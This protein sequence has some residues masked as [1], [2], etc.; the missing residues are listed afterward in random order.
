M[1]IRNNALFGMVALISFHGSAWGA[2]TGSI[3]G[4]LK[5]PDGLVIAGAMVT[6]TNEAQGVKTKTVTGSN[7]SIL[8]PACQW[9]VT[10][11]ISKLP[12]LSPRIRPAL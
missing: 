5:D 7:G 4:R 8:F 11:S 9:G 6:I 10:T 3:T 12:D 2:V 1:R